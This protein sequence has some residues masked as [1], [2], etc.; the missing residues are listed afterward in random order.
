MTAKEI[1]ERIVEVLDKLPAE[2]LEGVLE[3]VEFIA[4]PESVEA[5][6][7]ELEA[8]RRGDEEYRKGEFV[9]WRDLRRDAPV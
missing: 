3:Y 5:T 2:S 1:K 4:E 8:I 6:A 7:E 9:R